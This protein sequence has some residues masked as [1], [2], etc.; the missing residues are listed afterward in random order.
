MAIPEQ[1][2]LPLAM[3]APRSPNPRAGTIEPVPRPARSRSSPSFVQPMAARVVTV[4]P[5]GNDWIY[6]LKF[7]GTFGRIH[8]TLE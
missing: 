7:D 3:V 6:E 4:L 8:Q 1:T 2:W 5:A